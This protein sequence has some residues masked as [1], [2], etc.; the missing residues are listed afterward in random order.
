MMIKANGWDLMRASPRL[1]PPA[2][3]Q[4]PSLS[5]SPEVEKYLF[6]EEESILYFL[7][8][9]QEASFR[10]IPYIKNFRIQEVLFDINFWFKEFWNSL[11]FLYERGI[12]ISTSTGKKRKMSLRYGRKCICLL[13]HFHYHYTT[14]VHCSH[15][16][17]CSL[18]RLPRQKVNTQNGHCHC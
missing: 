18:W 3:S 4:A 6:S 7:A 16:S 9:C 12:Q 14:S 17:L 1:Y 2:I 13:F 11:T 10:K 8:F 15:S 5:V